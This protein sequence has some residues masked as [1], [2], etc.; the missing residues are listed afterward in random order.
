MQPVENRLFWGKRTNLFLSK[1]NGKL[2]RN[3]GKRIAYI[4][5]MKKVTKPQ[6]IQYLRQQAVAFLGFIVM[7]FGVALFLL[8]ELGGD[9][10]Q[11]FADGIHKHLGISNGM[12]LTLLHAS[13]FV[14]LLIFQR[15]LVRLD[16]LIP[17]F[18]TGPIIDFFMFLMGD[19]ITPQLPMVQ[20]ILCSLIGCVFLGM[21]LCFYLNSHTGTAPM[22]CFAVI[23][24]E[25][26]HIKLGYARIVQ[27]A[28]YFMIGFLLGGTYGIGTVIAVLLTGFY[29]NIFTKVGNKT[30]FK[31]ARIV[32]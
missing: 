2:E 3:A 28:T 13:F 14:F 12:A 9:P 26:A 10:G 21:G 11:V 29:I 19:F 27:D 31:W 30:L 15:K 16:M 24:S 18:V 1:R 17:T 4:M 7:A 22:D 8:V 6:V 25:K 20:R 5:E 32:T 23:L